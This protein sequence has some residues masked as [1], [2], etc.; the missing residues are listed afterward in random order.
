MYEK[1]PFLGDLFDQNTTASNKTMIQHSIFTFLSTDTSMNPLVTPFRLQISRILVAPFIGILTAVQVRAGDF[2]HF[3]GH[4]VQMCF[5]DF[6]LRQLGSLL[7]LLFCL[8]LP[9]QAVAQVVTT[10][11]GDGTAALLNGTGTGARFN[12]PSRVVSDGAGG[13]LYVADFSNHCIRRIV[14]ATGVVTT[15]AGSG[16]AGFLDA[17]GTAA[18]F[19][20]PHALWLDGAGNLYVS[21]GINGARIR[22]VAIATGAV[23]TFAG[24]GV[25][26]FVNGPVA[27]AQFA[28]IASLT[29]DGAGNL[30]VSDGS[31]NVIRRIV[32]ATGTV[33]TLAG[34]GAFGLNN[35]PGATATFDN[36]NGIGCDGLNVYVCDAANFCIRKIVIATGVVSTLSGGAGPGVSDGV[37]GVAQF[38]GLTGDMVYDGI[39]NFYFGDNNR[40]RSISAATGAVSTI[41]GSGTAGFADGTGVAAQFNEALGITRDAAG[42]LYIGDFNNHRIR[43]LVLPTPTVTSFTATTGYPGLGIIINGTNFSTAT[44]VRFGGV[45]SPSFTVLS[46]TQIV[47]AVPTGGASGNVSVTTPSGTGVLVGGF[48]FTAVVP[49]LSTFAGNAAPAGF[50]D[51][52]GGAARFN[53][54]VGIAFYAGDMYVAD[55]YN[56][57]VRRITPTGVVT[58]FAGSG[59]AGTADGTGAA[60]Q[61]SSPHGIAVD[62]SGNLFVADYFTHRIRVISAGG[63][64]TTLAGS[65]AG[66]ND[67]TGA[68]AQFNGPLGVAFSGGIVYVSD[69]LGHRIRKITYPG[70]VV[71]TLAG[72]GAPGFADATGVAAQFDGPR[73]IA[74]DAAGNVYVAD[75]NNQRI[76]KITPAGV[77]TTLAGSGVPGF[78]DATGAAAQ[79]NLPL[80][81]TV[82]AAG[83]L[84][85]CDGVNARIRVVS[86][87]GVVTTLAGSGTWGFADGTLAA[88][89]FSW[90]FTAGLETLAFDAS[91]NLFAVDRGN[92]AI[93]RVAAPPPTITSFTATT[94]YPG[95]GVIINGANFST[96]TQVQFGGVSSPSF[97]I[98]SQSQIV[99][100]VPTGGVSGNVSVTTP[101]G[102]VSLGGFTFTAVVPPLSTFAG[103][104]A[105]AG[106]AD[107]TSGGA[108]FNGPVGIAFYAGDMFVTDQGNNRVRRITPT[109]VVTTFAGSGAFATVDG[110]G[111]AASFAAPHG[112]A[113]DASGNLFVADYIT[114]RIRVISSGG[115]VTTLAGSTAGWNDATGAAA[116]FNGPL[117]VAFSGG[118]VYVSDFL[119]HRIRKITYPGGV[120]TTL[121]G[122][123][124]PGFADATG[125]AAQFNNPRGIAVDAAGNVYVADQGNHR[126]RKIT[127]A[128]VVTTLA[129]SGT[130]GFTDATGVLA[131]FNLPSGVTVDATSTL[132]V[133][134]ATNPRIRVV[135]PGGVVT[136]LAGS[137]TVGFADGT[138]AAGQFAIAMESLSLDASGN[139]FVADR[140]NNAIRR[141]AAQPPTVTGFTPTIAYALQV[142]TVNGTNF[143]GATQ[144][145]FGGV[146]APWFEVVSAT[147]IRAVVPIGGASG[148]VSVT[149]GLGT[150]S[151]A[152]FTFTAT[153]R[154]SSFAGQLTGGYL[155]AVGGGAQF[156]NPNGIGVDALGNIYVAEQNNHRIR[157][158][159]ATGVVTTFAGSG[160]AGFADNTGVL[161]QFSAPSGVACDAAG[162]VYIGDEGN[163]CIRKITPLGVVTTLAGLGGTSGFADGTGTAAR[164]NNPARLCI[165]AAGN[166][167]VPDASNHR[168][169]RVTPGGVVTTIAGSGTA[170]SLDGTGLAAQFNLPTGTAV[171]AAGNVYV[172]ES[173]GNRIRKISPAGV[174]TTLAGNGTASSVDGTGAAATVNAPAGLATDAAGMLYIIESASNRVRTISQ[175]GVVTTFAGTGTAGLVDG[176]LTASQFAWMRGAVADAAGNLYITDTGN[177]T[178]RKISIVAPVV[179]SFTPTNAYPMQAVTITG[180]DFF[181]VTQVRFGGINA[182]WFESVSP[183]QIRAVVPFGALS[184]SVTVTN[185]VGM[186]TFGGFTL[187]ATPQVSTLAGDGTNNF[188]DAVGAGAQLNF[189]RSVVSDGAGGNLYVTEFLGFRIRKIVVATGVVTTLA[190]SGAPGSVDG[191]GTAAQFSGLRD[192]WFDGA[193]NLYV[194]DGLGSLIRKVVIATGAVTTFAGTGA[195]GFV[196]GPAASAQF[197]G[198][199]GIT[200]DGAGNLYVSEQGND[201]IRKI[202]IGTG[203]VSTFVGTGVAGFADGPGASAQFN[204]PTGI[205]SDGVNLYVADFINYRIRKIVIAT[206]AVSTLSGTGVLGNVDGAAGV[207]QFSSPR[208]IAFDGS[209]N[210]FVADGF[211]IRSVSAATGA[212]STLAGTGVSGF[213]DGTALSAQFA[214]PN[215]ITID[216]AGILYVSD[217]G[218]YSIRRIV[219]AP[220]TVTGFAATTGYPGLGVIITGTNLSTVTQVRFGGVVS[221]S[222][223]VLSNTQIVAAVPTGGAT[224]TVQVTN[225]GG[226]G[227]SVG[228]FTFTAVIPPLSTFAGNA[229]PG[230]FAD[231]TQGAARLNQPIG[232]VSDGTNMFFADGAN[233][234]IRRISAT[235]VVTTF[236]GSGTSGFANGT[237]TAAQF[238]SPHGVA[239]DFLGNLYVADYGNHRIRM[240]TAGGVVTTLAG[241]GVAGFNDATGAAAQFNLPHAILF[242]GGFLYVTEGAGGHRIR[243]IDPSTGVVI[244]IAGSA[245]A[246]NADGTGAAA[247]FDFPFGMANDALGNIYIADQNNHRIRMMTTGGVVT[248]FAG[249][250]AGFADGTGAAAQFTNPHGIV[251]EGLGN[252]YITDIGNRR[253]RYLSSAGVVTTIA[254]AGTTGFTD[255]TLAAGQFSTQL[256]GLALNSSGELFIADRGNNA[257]RRTLPPSPVVTSF[258]ATTGYP[259]LGVIINGANFSAATQVQFGGVPSPSFTIIS[260]SQIVAAVPMGGASGSVSVTAPSGTGSLPGFTFTAVVPPVSTFAGNGAPAGFADAQQGAAQFNSNC[261]IAR[262][263]AGNIYVADRLNHRIRRITSAGVV[264]TFA[265]SGTAGSMNGIGAAAEFN[266]PQAVALNAAGTIL[267]VGEEGGHRIRQINLATASVTTLA[268]SGVLGWNDATGTAAQFNAPIGLWVQASGD[269]LV[270]DSQNHR[271]RRVTTGGIV[272]TIAGSGTAGFADGS[273]ASAQFNTPRG[274]SADAAGN[275]FVADHI[276]HSI[277]KIT[278]SGVVTTLAGSGVAGG[279]DGVGTAAQ[280]N[281]PVQ[282]WHDAVENIYVAE[283]SGH[284]IRVISPY[285]VVTRVAGTGAAAHIDGTTLTGQFNL[286]TGIL[287]N[288]I[289]G[290]LFVSGNRLIRKIVLPAPTV[291]SFNATTGYPGLGVIITG[292]N[293]ATVTQVQFGGVVSPS[294]TVLSNTQ[295]VAAVPTGGASGNVQVTNP[296]GTASLGGFTFTATI[297]Q[298][299]AFTGN[300]APAGF[301][302]G[303]QGAV[304]FNTPVGLAFNGIGE[305]F[306]GDQNNHRIRKITAAGVV[307]TFAGNGTSGWADGTGAAAQF[308]S[309][310]G[311]ATD[312]A[313]NVYVADFL[314]HRIR[315][316]TP[317]GV[318][319]TLAGSGVAGFNDATGLAAQ[320]NGPGGVAVSGGNLY[321]SDNSGHRIRRIVIA[322]GVVTTLAGSGTAGFADGTGVA[323]QFSSPQGL[324][325]DA[326]GNVY[327]ADHI[328]QRIRKITPAGVVTTLAGSGAGGFADGTGA[329]AQFQ[330]P[331]GVGV[332]AAGNVYVADAFNARVRLVS[333][334]GVVTTLAGSGTIGFVDG[335]LASGQFGNGLMGIALN[336]TN[337]LFVSDRTNNAIRRVT[338]PTIV[339]AFT[340]T[341]AG[342]GDVV[343]ITGINFTGATQVQFGGVNAASYTVVNATTITATPAAGGATGSVS[344]TAPLGTSSLVGFTFLPNVFYSQGM[345]DVGIRTNWNSLPGGGGVVPTLGQWMNKAGD[346]YILQVTAPLSTSLTIGN[347]VTMTNAA[348]ATLNM[349]ANLT[350]AAGGTYTIPLGASISA[351]GPNILTNNGTL[352]VAGI[353]GL[354]NNPTYTGASPVYVAGSTL[355]YNGS[356]NSIVGAEWLPTMPINVIIVLGKDPGTTLTL[357][358]NRTVNGSFGMFSATLALAANT[359][360]LNGPTDLSVGSSIQGGA[361]S[362]L[363]IG[364]AGTLLGTLVM[365]AP[366]TLG[367]G[368]TMNRSG[369]VLTLGSPLSATPVTLNSGGGVNTGAFAH[370]FSALSVG[371]GSTLTVAAGSTVS[372]LANYAVN[373]TIDIDGIFDAGATVASGTG[374][375]NINAVGMFSTAHPAGLAGAFTNTGGITYNGTVRIQG[376]TVGNSA[377]LNLVNLTIDRATA[378]T[379]PQNLNVSGILNI[380]NSGNFDLAGRQLSLT[381]TASTS[382]SATG[383]IDANGVGSIVVVNNTTLDGAHFTGGAIRRLDVVSVPTLSNSLAITGLLNM[384]NNLTLAAPNG[385]LWLRT[386]ATLNAPGTLIQGTNTT[387]E[388]MIDGGFNA[389]TMPSAFANPYNGA[390][391]FLGAENLSGTLT[392]SAS[393]GALSLGGNVSLQAASTLTLNQTSANSLTGTNTLQGVGA[394]SV[395]VLG[396]G[397][398]AGIIPANR[399]AATMNANMTTPGGTSTLA[400]G[401]LTLGAAQ[402]LTLGGR[403]TTSLANL[404][405]VTNT[406]TTSIAGASA[407]NYIDGPL[408]RQLLGGIAANGTTYLMPI[409]EGVSYRPMTLR[410]IRTGASPVVRGTVAASGATLPDNLTILTL[411][412]GRN[413]QLE[414]LSGVFTSTTLDLTEGGLT[415]TDLIGISTTQA[416]TYSSIG[417]TPGAGFV[418]SNVQAGL[419]DRFYA[420]AGIP[421]GTFYYNET[422]MGDAS[423]PTSWNSVPNG[424]GV[425]ATLG[426]MTSGVGTAFIVRSGITANGSG[427][428]TFGPNVTLTLQPTS[429]L[430]VQTGTL[431]V[432]G[433]ANVAGTL[434]IGDGA[435]L[436]NA[437]T[438]TIA[439]NGALRLIGSGAVS[440]SVPVYAATTSALEYTGTTAKTVGSEWLNPLPFTVRIANAGGV[441][442]PSTRTL[443]N[444]ANVTVQPSGVLTI[445]DGVSLVNDGNMIVS[446]LGTIRLDGSGQITGASGITYLSTSTLEFSNATATANTT[447]GG[448]AFPTPMNANVVVNNAITF[449]ESKQINGSWT[450]IGGSVNLNGNTLT[451]NDAIAFGGTSFVS[452]AG[453]G[454][455]IAGSSTLTGLTTIT[456]GAIGTLTMNRAGATLTNT[457]PVQ[458]SSILTLQNGFISATLG[459]ITLTNPAVAGLVGG[460]ATSYIVGGLERALQPSLS[461]STLQYTFPV[462]K[463]GVYLPLI[464]TNLTTG[465]TAPIVRTEAFATGISGSTLSTTG[466]LSLTEYWQTTLVSGT[467]TSGAAILTRSTLAASNSTAFAPNTGTVFNP[468]GG[469]IVGINPTATLT[470]GVVTDLG[471]FVITF[472][473][474][475]LIGDFS[476]K[477]GGPGTVV[478]ITGSGFTGATAVRFGG[479]NAASYTINSASS[480]TAT[481][482]AGATGTIDVVTP[483][484]TGTSD[485]TFTV[486]GPPTITAFTPLGGPPGTVVTLTGTNFVNVSRVRFRD[487]SG[488]IPASAFTVLSPTQIQ[489]TVPLGGVGLIQVTATGGTVLSTSPFLPV[490]PPRITSFSPTSGRGGTLVTILGTDLSSVTQVEF[491]GARAL[492]FSR[493]SPTRLDAIVAI[494]TLT[495]PITLVSPLGSTTSSQ[496]FTFTTSVMATTGTTTALT[497][498][499]AAAVAGTKL[500]LSGGR[501][502]GVRSVKISNGSTVFSILDLEYPYLLDSTR[503]RFPMPAL[504]FT[505]DSIPMKILFNSGA[506]DDSVATVYALQKPFIKSVQPESGKP[507]TL[508]S[509]S[510]RYF[511]NVTGV[512]FEG[513]PVPT[514]N[515]RVDSDTLILAA[516]P[517]GIPFGINRITVQARVAESNGEQ[518]LNIPPYPVITSQNLDSGEVGT[519]VLLRGE[520]F[521][522]TTNG[523]TLSVRF[524]NLPASLVQVISTTSVLAVV[525][526]GASSGEIRLTTGWGSALGRFRVTNPIGRI[527]SF[528]PVIGGPWTRVQLQGIRFDSTMVVS[529]A[530]IPAATQ[531]LDATNAIATVPRGVVAGEAVVSLQTTLGTATATGAF[532][533]LPPPVITNIDPISAGADE[534]ITISGKNFTNVT[535]LTLNASSVQDF[536]ILSDTSIVGTFMNVPVGVGVVTAFNV[537]GQ[538]SYALPFEL[539]PLSV[540]SA[541]RNL[542]FTPT[543]GPTGT[544]IRITGRNLGGIVGARIGG[545]SVAGIEQIST[546]EVIVIVGRGATGAIVLTNGFGT[547]GSRSVFRYQTPLELDSLALVAFYQAHRAENAVLPRNWLTLNRLNTWEGVTVQLATT[548]GIA[549]ERI[550]GVNLDGKLLNGRM[551]GGRLQ[552]GVLARL[553]QLQTF[554]MSNNQLSSSISG[555]LAPFR[556]LREVRLAGNQF[557]G[558]ITSAFAPEGTPNQGLANQDFPATLE[559]LDLRRNSLTGSVAVGLFGLPNLRVLLL[560]DNGFTGALLLNGTPRLVA[561]GIV[562]KGAALQSVAPL[563]RL[564]ISNNQLSGVFPSEIGNF[565]GL[566]T[567]RL[568][569]NRLAGAVPSRIG[570]CVTL[571]V[572]DASNNN[573][574][575]VLPQEIRNCGR[576]E[577]LLLDNNRLTA[578][579]DMSIMRRRLK[580]LA[581]QGNRLDFGALEANMVL[582]TVRYIPQDTINPAERSVTG[583]VGLP[584]RIGVVVGGVQNIFAWDV[585]GRAIERLPAVFRLADTGVYVCRITNSRVPGLT[586]VTRSVQV[587]GRLPNPPATAP[588][589]ILPQQNATGIPTEIPI[590]LGEVQYAAMYEIQVSLT[591]DFTKPLTTIQL[592]STATTTSALSPLT[593]YYW[594]ARA[595]NAGGIGPWSGVQSFVTIRAGAIISAFAE[596]S[597]KTAIG[598]VSFGRLFL[599]NLTGQ[600]IRIDSLRFDEAEN[601]F[602]TRAA[603]RSL[604]LEAREQR[605]I[606]IAFAPKSVGRKTGNLETVFTVLSTQTQERDTFLNTLSGTGTAL[607]ALPVDYD[608]VIAGKAAILPAVLINRGKSTLRVSNVQF[609]NSTNGLI[610]GIFMFQGTGNKP[611]RESPIKRG[612]EISLRSGDTLTIITRA[613]PQQIG[614]QETRLIWTSIGDGADTVETPVTALVKPPEPADVIVRLGVR[615]VDIEGKP[616]QKAAPGVLAMLELYIVEGDLD[617]LFRITQP[618]F[619]ATIRYDRNVL[620]LANESFARAFRSD[621]SLREQRIIVPPTR[622][623]GRGARLGL[624]PLRVVAGD[625]TETAI[626]IETSLWGGAVSGIKAPWERRVFVIAPEGSVFGAIASL[627]GGKRLITPTMSSLH[628]AG[629]M[630]NP[631]TEQIEVVYTLPKNDMLTITLLDTRGNEVQ[632]L[633]SEL[634]TAGEH[635]TSFKLRWLSSGSYILR[636]KTSTGMV[637]GRVEVVR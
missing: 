239:T 29:G 22:R 85:V 222:F 385:R 75:A 469:T 167:Y 383:T 74:V 266:L 382:T 633:L 395:I 474:S 112:I 562:S 604:T 305:M 189:P 50:A 576:L 181:G 176:T 213:A 590:E 326:A 366:Q 577:A 169:R 251:R 90:I 241:S 121:A 433:T 430:T 263:A 528:S 327:V 548:D 19:Q 559:I 618:E 345:A 89:Q 334:L 390:I 351:N 353:L 106:F 118:I 72:S 594:R 46:N 363:T 302:D 91:N 164:F 44:Q 336:A 182:A 93:R 168:I 471:R 218:N 61:F 384:L 494:S 547:G 441:R 458:V 357:P 631:V 138:L 224:G 341:S 623:N 170:A 338:T 517:N 378:V 88:G 52:T 472:P 202:V 299:S 274:V 235:G 145:Q 250:T 30:F 445:G 599:R 174:V 47:A 526:Q 632:Q 401:N 26:G 543:L 246:G 230:G 593:R 580:M 329:A 36:P 33:S 346:T 504:A 253:I 66:W 473:S 592:S 579:P 387:S 487:F 107:G 626:E 333:P 219:L 35:G 10:L 309:P 402:I 115:A 203:T 293:L 198:I 542:V 215:G 419:G 316:I 361:T 393:A 177:N 406:A 313:N 53:E 521:F 286:P 237:G 425:A 233:H 418:R 238:A 486:I 58:T 364:G 358:A 84:Y 553:D 397:F 500:I 288:P 81:V 335:A 427:S 409:G 226:T 627:A 108:R 522:A 347:G 148:N 38:L 607:K 531:F 314:N 556:L 179:T 488:F 14:V 217:L 621:A 151:F 498:E 634:Q 42:I 480:I 608:T 499:P 8:S 154:V 116:Q 584:L 147:Q 214:G 6:P 146:T 97:T 240:I 265:G 243:R 635:K 394:T 11:A 149:T 449:T 595:A 229:A 350:I 416:G 144:V 489:V 437:G 120:V 95:L 267:Y 460:S 497:I 40:I 4:V 493:I 354:V 550:T 34:T 565:T 153:P 205:V 139:V 104:A 304:R 323:A 192:L 501:V 533:V 83:Y 450:G 242:S 111:A 126:I 367:A 51:G 408:E 603:F 102:T 135:S 25:S 510:G 615:T 421:P 435:T 45:V 405:R 563:E 132:Y 231:G 461:A 317:S 56:H 62:A 551:T 209:G 536:R 360:T 344:V 540:A 535:S 481:L 554:N 414:Q 515:Y 359:L 211:N 377:G 80:G 561:E 96:A 79:F 465:V 187:A 374:G 178:I 32:I 248:T 290:E 583:I 55:Q 184:G 225:P 349:N 564:E 439:A 365:T 476:P 410:D 523:V 160:V 49:P 417:G 468:S 389:G 284:I 324:A 502:K 569:G 204:D 289:T 150:G 508:V 67:A 376:A 546:T 617:S 452:N 331:L 636:L 13:N 392:M 503:I 573:L 612:E 76:R 255:G 220:P 552:T 424:S 328:N 549:E 141:I 436:A 315:A 585:G 513:V 602:E 212:V 464:L 588:L 98:I 196:N 228:T 18:Q 455:V 245:T 23:T 155:D 574:S 258:N 525:P 172:A 54:P 292:T 560:S 352:N 477:S 492:T 39:G 20:N 31:N 429:S 210:L 597:P 86:P 506:F 320:F 159:T 368:L 173:G 275:V 582:D 519:S 485:S 619:T 280:L 470:S 129:G 396:N 423:L 606:V 444:T 252:F 442:L 332:D 307:T 271:I 100:A 188:R 69:F 451:L 381:A 190:G 496:S 223:T 78:A 7:V 311:I 428:L 9:T 340:P 259:G 92:N 538:G 158:I 362:G 369:S 457:A 123:G 484:G 127:P 122:S 370:T 99:A 296:G 466:S 201:V 448:K 355:G 194:V 610:S 404:L 70:G 200:G 162:N 379:L 3:V 124:T 482:A 624:I 297:P 578:L 131:Q 505:G 65:T 247:Q 59:T 537:G 511:R 453:S 330:A 432:N 399:F 278:P 283:Q 532:I 398:N 524:N 412:S 208:A 207:A 152:G 605:T 130:A 165:D 509:I 601:S 555:T 249:S 234:V 136:T 134:D 244:T 175:S 21:D 43:R 16:V 186:G 589:L 113:A 463:N 137:G 534:Q 527:T 391:T 587:L 110:I 37:A 467:Y 260:A 342:P 572:L 518:W 73:G 539:L 195:A 291:T 277:R 257:I 191:T 422:L 279:V 614:L 206:G 180:T 411:L 109:G 566:Q 459:M 596:N 312:A 125:L 143:S 600:A 400:G 611:L 17:T 479:V 530:G 438:T 372:Q 183:T 541:P 620:T 71:T 306:I 285:G 300:A 282:M 119:G 625:T 426:L 557:T 48:T 413:W 322:T 339:T 171:D 380:A 490:A 598:D 630:P 268:G 388:V 287:G 264:T 407:T 514:G 41:A 28:G 227:T 343:T 325:T 12:S 140:V 193:G 446:G 462:A 629:I 221:P 591:E 105:P 63:V 185:S 256:S 27:S 103:N 87:A 60:A 431:T 520:N 301:A 420:I 319:T 303:T 82:D 269:I 616:L 613:E 478:T 558:E 454:L 142:V 2:M 483:L 373:G 295:I 94:G 545:A 236:A 57:R 308:N 512:R 628:L 356:G 114:N 529:F 310:S 507:G 375:I 609:A 276:N 128:G 571:Q 568:N 456:G 101:N 15:L 117:G 337:S 161:A 273:A 298:V 157:K 166:L 270:A 272:T 544:R 348:G 68:A 1:R 581:V 199:V 5:A 294:F 77:V 133:S 232:I 64:V 321:V 495:G 637:T 386:A 475:V 262:D 586:L 447:A 261:H 415:P 516:A 570:E 156:V 163:H 567:L 443:A 491:T 434:G 197:S 318:V 216:A 24:T 403:L 575:G 440:G 371:A 254:G 281:T 622:W